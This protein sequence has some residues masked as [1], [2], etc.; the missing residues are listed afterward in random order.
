MALI[1]N[2]FLK[3]LVL[4]FFIGVFFC[5]G[6]E[7]IQPFNLGSIVF[8]PIGQNMPKNWAEFKGLKTFKFRGKTFRFITHGA[9]DRS[10][11]F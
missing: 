3:V 4:Q 11:L 5:F 10:S 8:K 1:Y 7:E 6:L 2:D 9:Q